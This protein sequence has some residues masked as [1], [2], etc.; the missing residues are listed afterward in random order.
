MKH[1]QWG[2]M[3][4]RGQEE[5]QEQLKWDLR[6]REVEGLVMNLEQ[7]SWAKEGAKEDIGGGR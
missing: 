1:W 3:Q 5:E 6:R 7:G 2:V 4:R